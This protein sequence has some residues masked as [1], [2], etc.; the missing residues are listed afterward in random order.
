[1]SFSPH[2]LRRGEWLAGTGAVVLLVSMF[3]L[4]WYGPT[5]TLSRAAGGSGL[6]SSANAWHTLTTARWVM[7]ITIVLALALAYFQGARRSPAVP[8]SLSVFVTVFALITVVI[9]IDRVLI[10]PPGGDLAEAKAGAY[11]GL[12]SAIVM[13]LGGFFSMRDEG[14]H[15]HD[16]PQEIERLRV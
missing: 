12:L 13:L 15:H 6:S 16:G 2:R 7:L 4:S 11:I 3:L 9:L 14:I 8:V 10:D 1:M 5:S